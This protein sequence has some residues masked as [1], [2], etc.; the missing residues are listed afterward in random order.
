MKCVECEKVLTDK[1]AYGHDC[2]I[3]C[4]YADNVHSKTNYVNLELSYFEVTIVLNVLTLMLKGLTATPAECSSVSIEML[5][6]TINSIQSEV[7]K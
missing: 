5:S 1:D 7:A 4:K 3:V 2:E 6:D